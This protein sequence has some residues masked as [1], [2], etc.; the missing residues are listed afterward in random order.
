MSNVDMYGTEGTLPNVENHLLDKLNGLFD[1]LIP[2]LESLERAVSGQASKTSGAERAD[3]FNTLLVRI[4]E[5][6][7]NMARL[8]K[9]VETLSLPTPPNMMD[10]TTVKPTSLPARPV[11]LYSEKAAKA[12]NP[13]APKGLPPV[14]P[15]SYMNQFKLGQVVIRKKFDQPKP[16]EGLTAASICQKINK[17]LSFAKANIENELIQ[18]KV[19]AQFPNRDVKIFT[20]D[21]Q[22]AKWLLNNKHLWTTKADPVFVTSQVTHAPQALRLIKKNM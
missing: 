13:S 14:P 20:K 6:A 16:F 8:E 2:R 21:L 4:E 10:H 3:S 15:S 11:P 9:K 22:A 5:I 7:S 12:P 18:V 17:A 19:V 1:T